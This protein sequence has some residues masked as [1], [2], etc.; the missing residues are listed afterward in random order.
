LDEG[1]KEKKKKRGEEHR[2]LSKKATRRTEFRDEFV[3]ERAD[4]RPSTER[5]DWGEEILR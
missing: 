1:E 4:A 5:V 3:G 2:A